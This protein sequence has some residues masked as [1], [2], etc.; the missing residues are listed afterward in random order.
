MLQTFDQAQH[1]G[2]LG[3][4]RHPPQPGQMAPAI[5]VTTMRERIEAMALLGRQTV[6]QATTGER[7]EQLEQR[8]A[9]RSGGVHLL[10]ERPERDSAFF[11]PVTVAGRWG[12]GGMFIVDDATARAILRCGAYELMHRPEIPTEIVIDEYLEIAKS[13]FD[14]P[15]PAFINGALDALARDQRAA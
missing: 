1:R 14:G 15:E 9:L 13:F 6:D 4:L 10:G 5:V 12:D 8:F 7:F 3:C 11:R 2:R